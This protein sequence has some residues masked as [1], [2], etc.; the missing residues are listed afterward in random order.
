MLQ[1]FC[2]GICPTYWLQGCRQE[3]KIHSCIKREHPWMGTVG[4]L[5]W[6]LV[7]TRIWCGPRW[8]EIV[9]WMVWWL[10]SWM[11]GWKHLWNELWMWAA[12]RSRWHETSLR[13]DSSTGR[14]RRQ[15]TS[16]E[17]AFNGTKPLAAWNPPNLSR[18][19]FHQTSRLPGWH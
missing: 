19:G 10:D 12:L 11:V 8:M 4:W 9:G 2:S 14:R 18:Y 5:D 6:D 17:C 13:A 16:L 15:Q 7:G 3:D 1:L